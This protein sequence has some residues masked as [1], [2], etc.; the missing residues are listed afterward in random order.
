VQYTC[1]SLKIIKYTNVHSQNEIKHLG[2]NFKTSL[3]RS[4]IVAIHFVVS[5]KLNVIKFFSEKKNH[6]EK[7]FRWNTVLKIILFGP[8]KW[9][10]TILKLVA[11]MLKLF[12]ALSSLK[13]LH[14]Y[15]DGL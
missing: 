11:R 8:S 6:T 14:N 4:I 1:R 9:L 7:R 10:C 12:A 3:I 13:F 5:K 2:L 15:F